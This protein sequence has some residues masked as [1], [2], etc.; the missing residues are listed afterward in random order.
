MLGFDQEKVK[1]LL[2]LPEHVKF[3]AMVPFGLP[4]AEG[5]PH[6]RFS[7]NKIVTYH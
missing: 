1:E 4:A 5:Y 3:A 7:L 6:H 2:G